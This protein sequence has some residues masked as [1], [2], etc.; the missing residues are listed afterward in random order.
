MQARM[1]SCGSM[2]TPR[3]PDRPSCVPS[4]ATLWPESSTPT[5]SHSIRQSGSWSTLIA[6]LCGTFGPCNIRDNSCYAVRLLSSY[7]SV[8]A[9]WY[10]FMGERMVRV[11]IVRNEIP[12]KMVLQGNFKGKHSLH[13]SSHSRKH[14]MTNT[15]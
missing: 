14:Q 12:P 11:C 7:S 15:H 13:T 9:Q 8:R 1:R 4:T 5:A 6:P 3:T 2:W 10:C